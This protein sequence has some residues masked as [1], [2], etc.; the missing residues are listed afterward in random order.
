MFDQG[1]SPFDTI[2]YLALYGDPQ[3]PDGAAY[4]RTHTEP[5]EKHFIALAGDLEA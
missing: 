3:G 1:L 2:V 5:G 4:E